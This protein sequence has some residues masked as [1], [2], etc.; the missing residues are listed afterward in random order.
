MTSVDPAPRPTNRTDELRG[1]LADQ[2]V[3]EDILALRR[4]KGRSPW[5]ESPGLVGVV[6]L[7]LSSV[8]SFG[9]QYVTRR[10]DEQL[11]LHKARLELAQTRISHL[12]ELLSGLLLAAERRTKMAQG[13]LDDLDTTDL[14]ILRDSTNAAD[15]R[16]ENGKQT[17]EFF[18]R[19]HFG[20]DSSVTGEWERVRASVQA[21]GDCADSVYR[22]FVDGGSAPATACFARHD[23]AYAELD[24]F[25]AV[26]LQGYRKLEEF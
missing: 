2:Q 12:A 9:I 23:S 6:T 26:L 19:F 16:W 4:P 24:R 21:Y 8:L 17:S 7:V 20:E 14:R 1:L 3:L 13:R 18:I 10:S 22:K 11:S 5:H 15:E 25:T